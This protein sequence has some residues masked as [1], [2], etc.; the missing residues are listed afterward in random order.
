VDRSRL[1]DRTPYLYRTRDYGA[2]WQLITN[3]IGANSFLRGIRQD[4]DAGSRSLL[5]AGTELGVYV[6][7]DDGDHWQSLQ[8]NLPFTSVRDL[9]IHAEDLVIATHGRSYWILDNITPLRQAS[10]AAKANRFWLYR[11][12]P[13]F[14]IDNDSFA[15][16]TT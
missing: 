13:A 3:G 12:A 4:K 7:F 16:N 15:G 1:D 5:F 9:S 2:S 6:S 11:P 8:L 14:R 10:E